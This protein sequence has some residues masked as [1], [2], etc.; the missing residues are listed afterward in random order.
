MH[1]SC[2]WRD[3]DLHAQVNYENAPTWFSNLFTTKFVWTKSKRIKTTVFDTATRH[4][5][6][7]NSVTQFT[8]G[9]NHVRNFPQKEKSDFVFIL[10][11]VQTF[12]FW[13]KAML[14]RFKSISSASIDLHLDVLVADSVGLRALCL[15]NMPPLWMHLVNCR[16]KCSAHTHRS[17]AKQ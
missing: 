13:L 15:V 12:Q 7:Y 9:F 16:R 11:F 2:I 6:V 3:F 5:G 8:L 14:Q 17:R 4:A 1:I 10:D